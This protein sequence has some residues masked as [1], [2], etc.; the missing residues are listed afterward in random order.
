MNPRVTT[1]IIGE[2]Y[3]LHLQFSNGEQSVF[4]VKPYLE[5]GIFKQLK[6]KHIFTSA[7][8]ENGTVTWNNGQDFCPDTLYIESK[9]ISTDENHTNKTTR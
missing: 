1:V 6:D 9:K 3:T 5:K 4:D 7:H 8:I 2:N